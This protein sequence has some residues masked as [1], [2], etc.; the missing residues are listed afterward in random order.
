MPY[1]SSSVAFAEN[2]YFRAF[3]R[4][5]VP[6]AAAKLKVPVCLLVLKVLSTVA[7]MIKEKRYIQ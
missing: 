1:Y 6:I 5:L 2:S 4:C 3:T 7:T